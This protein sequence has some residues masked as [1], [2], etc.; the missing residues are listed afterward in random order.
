M[1]ELRRYERSPQQFTV[2]NALNQ[3]GQDAEI[4]GR[5]AKSLNVFL[6]GKCKMYVLSTVDH[7]PQSPPVRETVVDSQTRYQVSSAGNPRMLGDKM[8]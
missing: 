1:Q 4:V 6:G 5:I 3:P 2:L 7:W 8:F